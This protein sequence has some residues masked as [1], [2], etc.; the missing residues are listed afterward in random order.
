MT[1]THCRL[2]AAA[3]ALAPCLLSL[4]VG[5]HRPPAVE[6]TRTGE[7]RR[8]Q[9]DPLAAL[10]DRLQRATDTA[11][12]RDALRQ[13]DQYLEHN[14]QA[15]EALQRDDSQIRSLQE[16]LG[17]R[18]D[19]VEEVTAP[20][21]QPLDAYHLEM[22]LLLREAG[23]SL[24]T[25]GLPPLQKAELAFDWAV[26]QLLL[27]ADRDEGLLVP[28]QFAL[29]AGVGTAQERALLFLALLQQLD[30]DGCMVGVPGDKGGPVHYWVPGALITEDDKEKGKEE[31]YLFDTRLGLPLPGPGGEGIATLRQLREHA[32]LLS[33]LNLQGGAR[34]DVTDEQARKAEPYLVLPLGALSPRMRYLESR[35]AQLDRVR[36]AVDPERLLK[37]FAAAT[38]AEVHVWNSRGQPDRPPPSTPTRML[39][40]FLPPDKGGVGPGGRELVFEQQLIP[41]GPVVQGYRELR[42]FDNLVAEAQTQLAGKSAQLFAKYA[43]TPRAYLTRGML[44]DASKRLTAIEAVLQEFQQQVL[45]PEI[46]L[47][48][49][50]AWREHVNQ[51]YLARERKE[52]GAQQRLK[53]VWEEDQYLLA[54]V[55]PSDEGTDLKDLERKMLTYI[56]LSATADPLGDEALYLLALD[57]QEKASRLQSGLAARPGAGA[58][59]DAAR[60]EAHW[61]WFNAADWAARYAEKHGLTP[62]V[63]QARL[64]PVRVPWQRGADDRNAV[65]LALWDHLFLDLRRAITAGLFQAHALRE[66]G[67]PAEAQ[68]VLRKL[69]AEAEALRGEGD[70]KAALQE[71]LQGAMALQPGQQA[72]VAA[73]LQQLTRELNP[74]GGIYWLGYAARYREQQLRKKG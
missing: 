33:Q 70:L 41:M 49:V 1:Q 26:R 22:C 43:Q 56:V 25:L 16:R 24:R 45:P 23:D 74:G 35:L 53:A 8:D 7:Q 39:R 31:V 46:A 15:R 47:Q 44:D 6:S 58:A 34:Y 38:G 10:L 5:C 36:L 66:D 3:L 68:D 2:R 19:E 11:S 54:L 17:L 37:R 14:P 67:K 50:A 71:S 27:R 57:W 64:R 18:P 55:S 42:V 9:E 48:R 40:L 21:F 69:A 73:W 20:T 60:K 12:C 30:I 32:E 65:V 72:A 63:L 28:P 4:C 13:A 62:A 29:R 52:P 51:A 61:G 59:D